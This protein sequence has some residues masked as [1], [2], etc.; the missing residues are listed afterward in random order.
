MDKLHLTVLYGGNSGEHE[1]SRRSAASVLRHLDRD[2]YVVTAIGISRDG[3]WHLQR[4][5]VFETLPSGDLSLTIVPSDHPVAIVPAAGLWHGGVRLA[6]DCV[7]P[8]LHGTHCEDGQLQGALDTAGLPYVGAG[9]LGSSAAMDKAVAKSLWR[10][11][12]LPIVDFRVVDANDGL[13]VLA[14]A[15]QAFGWPLF[16]KPCSAGS[17]LGASRA[18]TPAE[19]QTALAE[20]LR[21]DRRALIEPCLDVR[22]L[23]CSVLGN[24]E[25]TVFPPGEI[26]PN[27]AHA[28]YDYEAKYADPDG[29]SLHAVALVDATLQQSIMDI[30]RAAYAAVRCEGLGRVDFFVDKKTGQLFLN[31]I[32]TLPGFTSISMYPRMCEAGGLG[33]ADLLDRLVGL[34]L[35]RGPAI[36]ASRP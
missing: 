6:V 8:V 35:E 3:V 28:F 24:G 17:S 36:R 15:Q 5:P 2:R 1:V 7:F 22:E 30:A 21:H 16:V 31:E 26:V 25:I 13:D 10:D 14:E 4:D 12:G 9:V 32:N 18:N 23:E 19:L 27:A 20:A 33:Y 29:A 34:A 11:A